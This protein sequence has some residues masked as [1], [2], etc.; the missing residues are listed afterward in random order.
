M[1]TLCCLH[2][3]ADLFFEILNR[4]NDNLYKYFRHT[5]FKYH[6][7]VTCILKLS[8]GSYEFLRI[9]I[10]DTLNS[11]INQRKF[12]PYS[13]LSSHPN[14]PFRHYKLDHKLQGHIYISKAFVTNIRVDWKVQQARAYQKQFLDVTG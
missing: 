10:Q 8:G 7:R 12:K 14:I 11:F 13:I 2:Q 4:R 1:F 9:D 3:D 5:K 6:S